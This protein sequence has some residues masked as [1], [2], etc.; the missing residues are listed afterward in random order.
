MNKSIFNIQGGRWNLTPVV[1]K[2]WR[3]IS[4]KFHEEKFQQFYHSLKIFHRFLKYAVFLRITHVITK[5]LW[6][7]GLVFKPRT[8]ERAKW[9]VFFEKGYI[10]FWCKTL[11]RSHG[12]P[13]TG[14]QTR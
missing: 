3:H 2:Y 10:H 13:V 14:L 8:H 4:L 5:Y 1:E 11:Y 6:L 9:L 7:G 12:D